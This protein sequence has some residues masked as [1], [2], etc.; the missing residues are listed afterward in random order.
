MTK[1]CSTN[2]FT[3]GSTIDSKKWSSGDRKGYCQKYADWHLTRYGNSPAKSAVQTDSFNAVKSLVNAMITNYQAVGHTFPAEATDGSFSDIQN[4]IFYLCNALP[5]VCDTALTS[6]CA[7]V[8]RVGLSNHPQTAAFCGC[9]MPAAQYNIYNQYIPSDAKCDPLCARQGVIPLGKSLASGQLGQADTCNSNICII[10]NLSIQL[11]QSSVGGKGITINQMCSGCSSGGSSTSSNSNG[12]SSTTS[13]SSSSCQCYFENVNITTVSSS[14]GGGVAVN[15][16]CGN[17]PQ[18]ASSNPNDPN[19]KSVPVNCAAV[20]IIDPFAQQKIAQENAISVANNT[21]TLQYVLIIVIGLLVVFF[22]LFL[23]FRGKQNVA[24]NIISNSRS[25]GSKVRDEDKN[26]MD[27]DIST[28]RLGDENA[29]NIYGEEL[30]DKENST[31]NPTSQYTL[32]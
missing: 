12:T 14:I 5:G 25:N 32:L 6:K 3:S 29:N 8:T 17:T 19:G 10:D 27:N 30:S 16:L 4:Q 18:C 15:Q 1:A 2:F 24:S 21:Q 26:I 31:Y 7:G 9:H 22:F 20:G 11:A 23:I 13:N 28:Y